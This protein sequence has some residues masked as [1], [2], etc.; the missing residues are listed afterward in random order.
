MQQTF[1]DYLA[2]RPIFNGS[3]IDMNRDAK[4]LTGQILDVYNAMKDGQWR[5]LGAIEAI[6]GHGQA[7]ISAQMRNLRKR[8]FGCHTVEKRHIKNGLF[9]YRI[10]TEP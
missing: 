5:T 9:E 3:D 4:R 10:M 8:D 6:T 1:E 7:S 2:Q